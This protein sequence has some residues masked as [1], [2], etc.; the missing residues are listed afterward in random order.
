M[1]SSKSSNF[2]SGGMTTKIIAAKICMSNGCSTI[3]TNSDKKHPLFGI[4]L[5]NSTI[6][7]SQ[8]S[9]VS[10]RKKW[11][12]NHLH[13]SGSLIVDDGAIKAIK[14]NKSLLPAGVIDIKGKFS[15]GDIITI[16]ATNN[17]KIG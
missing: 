14:Q 4:T 7:H 5:K 3:I 12:L 16:L 15:R 6:F 1:A 2:G 10:S 17:D 9:T 11:L 13:P 8:I